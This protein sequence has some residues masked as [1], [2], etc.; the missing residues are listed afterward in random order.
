MS[1]SA[2]PPSKL[3]RHFEGLW[4]CACGVVEQRGGRDRVEHAASLVTRRGSTIVLEDLGGWMPV[5]GRNQGLRVRRRKAGQSAYPTWP[6][7]IQ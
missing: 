6:C 2:A 4:E 7:A 3:S 1:A 5:L